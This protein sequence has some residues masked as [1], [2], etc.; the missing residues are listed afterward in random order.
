MGRMYTELNRDK[1]NK[2]L[3]RM[4]DFDHCIIPADG[5]IS[6]FQA[7]HK[8]I[9]KGFVF[10]CNIAYIYPYYA[11]LPQTDNFL[12]SMKKPS[13]LDQQLAKLKKLNLLPIEQDENY[14]NL[15]ELAA[16]ICETPIALITLLTEKEQLF[17]SHHGTNLKQTPIEQSFC[18]H[19]V[20][21]PNDIFIVTDAR[22]NKNFKDNPVVSAPHNFIFYAGVPLVCTSGEVLGA[23]CVID[24]AP[25]ELTPQQQNALK[26]LSKQVVQLL[27]LRRKDI[28]FTDATNKLRREAANYQT[29]QSKFNKTLWSLNER[30]KEQEC[31][32]KITYLS[33]SESSIQDLLEKSIDILPEGYQYP[34]FAGVAITYGHKTIAS[35]NYTKTRWTQTTER[36]CISGKQL[37]ISVSY[38][39]RITE[40][41]E[42][43]F[44]KE[45]RKLLESVTD[46][47]LLS[48][49]QINVI[50]SN[51]L[52]LQSTD[53]GIYGINEHGECT[54]INRAA[55]KMLGFEE[56]ECIGKNM[57]EIVHYKS[58]DGE[59][60]EEE[61][62]PIYKSRN[63]V[64]GCRVES[65]VFW[66]K[67]G[68]K[69]YVR[70]SSTPIRF[71]N[72]VKGAV[73]VFND[74]S[75]IKESQ[76]Q[77]R[78]S[79]Q[80]FKTLVQDGLDLIGIL[81]LEGNYMYVSPTSTT[82]L[83]ITPEE[84]IG[85][86]AFDFIH[87]DDKDD[88]LS[89][90]SKLAKQKS[91]TIS[92]FRFIDGKGE[93]RWIESKV[94]NM[95]DNPAIGGIVAN[96]RD[97]TERLLNDER[98]MDSEQR[99]RALIENGTDGMAIIR[100][101]GSTSYISP[102]I[103]SVLG[104]SEKEAYRLN[105]FEIIHTED[106]PKVIEKMELVLKSPGVPIQGH[107]S[108][109]KHKD[110]SWR[111]LEATITN[112]IHDPNINGIVDNFRDVT[113]RIVADEKI[114]QSEKRFKSLVQEG[115]DLI[116]I[117]DFQGGF[118]YV[119]PNY[120][121]YLGYNEK[122]LL[123]K[124]GFSLIHPEDVAP[125][126]EQ[127]NQL[128][129]EKRIKSNPYRF[130][131]KTNGWRWMQSIGT[132]LTEDN[133]ISGIVV[134]SVDIT[135]LIS[136]QE[137][138]KKSNERFE[139][140]SK[141]TNDAIYDWDVEKDEFYW[142]DGFYRNFGYN[143]EGKVFTIEDWAA[144]THPI[145]RE[146]H[147]QSWD[148]FL[149]DKKRHLWTN[150]FR[151]KTVD[152]T[153]LFVEE[154]GHMIRDNKGKPIRMIGALRDITEF[155]RIEEQKQLQLAITN[156]FKN[157][158]RLLVCVENAIEHIL[159]TDEYS[160]CAV[161]LVSRDEQRLRLFS[162]SATNGASEFF[163]HK[164]AIQEFGFGEGVPGNVW[165]N[166]KASVWKN[167]GENKEFI[168]HRIAKKL[169]LKSVIG[170]PLFQHDSVVGVMILTSRSESL[171]DQ[172][173]PLLTSIEH[174]FGAE[175]KRKQQEEEFQ[176]FFE[177]APEILAIASA[178][179]SFSK[180]NPAFCQ[181]LGYT[182]KELTSQPFSNFIYPDD[183]SD[184]LQEYELNI[185][186]Q[187]KASGFINRYRKKS[188]E[189]C[190]ISWSSSDVFDQEGNIF[191]YGRDITE[192]KELQILLGNASK[193]AQ[194][195]SWEIDVLK[196]TVFW[197]DI[198]R[199]IREV[200]DSFEPTLKKGIGGF[201]KGHD[202][203]TIS[204][205][206]K[207]CIEDGTPWDEEL[208]IITEKGNL[209]WIRTIGEATFAE[210]K[211]IK[212]YGSFQDIHTKKTNEL[213]LKKTLNEKNNILESIGD[214][215]LS[216][217]RKWT[218]TY[219]NKE[220]E[221]I[222]RKNRKQTLGK[223]LWKVFSKTQH[224]KFYAEYSKAMETQ[225]IVHFEEYNHTTKQWLEVSVYPSEN[226]LSV[227]MKDIS[228]RVESEEQVRLSN[229]RFEKVSEATNDAIWDWDI[230]NKKTHWG[231]GYKTIFGYDPVKHPPTLETWTSRIHPEDKERVLASMNVLLEDKEASNW[232]HEYRYRKE[233]GEY[234]FVI[235]RGVAIRNEKGQTVRMVGAL[236]DITHRKESEESLIRLNKE[237]EIQ[238][239]E[240]AI[241]NEELEQFA[242]VTS[243]DL[244]EPLRMITSFLN[245]LQRKYEDKLDDKAQRYIHFAVDGA[246]RM[247]QII[248]DLLEFSRAGRLD[249]FSSA[250]LID[251]NDLI[252]EV[253]I[254]H[255]KK[256]VETKANIKHDKL[257]SI[258]GERTPLLQVF[259]NIISN[260]I[261]YQRDG[262]TPKVTIRAEEQNDHWL[263]HVEDN[264][265]GISD[266]YFDQI[267]IV[268]QRL[269]AREEYSGTGIGLSIV[270]KIIERMDGKIWV[271]SE[272][273]KG[274]AF[275]FT[276][277][278]NDLA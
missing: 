118:Q 258:L 188:G 104:Y 9:I 187:H 61:D 153:Y 259:Q 218:V 96:S 266:E 13:N 39:K 52:I 163:S 32:Y 173:I 219:W 158:E 123:G 169:G 209:K 122:E 37:E 217:D 253:K 124:D 7:Y 175:I 172:N 112:M 30:L 226:G 151:F 119:S 71:A 33:N 103:K 211:C 36:T 239:K 40:N 84:F 262:I 234:A 240:L 148:A 132:N 14:N 56:S 200:P 260:G 243:H 170:V 155:Q 256:I 3:K 140:V 156:F 182:A 244:Q 247:R 120:K 82:V 110:G 60:H 106:L 81:D 58:E 17:L 180:V 29:I 75:E 149:S 252:D 5:L 227:Y 265:I 88:F 83:G 249:E 50:T 179:G 198:T 115:A 35:Q 183:L 114:L 181:L 12:S 146:K 91:V 101:D 10:R 125:L 44:L 48:I 174:L 272:I 126:Y 127:L 94:T 102:S 237:L 161:W 223:N 74:I 268:F 263:F 242:F 51:Q 108:R 224:S 27:K 47:I 269:H 139:Y 273:G 23:L 196:G 121:Q 95:L 201:V 189:Y 86:N 53:E 87:P 93:W 186:S 21:K 167:I 267:F 232:Q 1:T 215:F 141:A 79:E 42:D 134:N 195:G 202:R 150:S 38:Q 171:S 214:A 191:A 225:K 85:K 11:K 190:W 24:H 19:A 235:D 98:L 230:L 136:A 248:L 22:K 92:P 68:T 142:G 254:L 176:L 89:N 144:L 205:K 31:L 107:T 228:L 246:Q 26:L 55:L 6:I 43:A 15:T 77:L 261:K 241:S 275:H 255:R 264:G 165:M 8:L 145:D 129:T 154:I 274:T 185:T 213:E 133:S 25:K 206:V 168:R 69:F 45:E 65:D 197:S 34:E 46:S 116:A 278:K 229:E 135:E 54:F 270:K 137:E 113:D 109:T 204:E 147:Q 131:H 257:P 138:L 184:T 4:C 111:W 152:N 194:V 18:A 277:P 130:K 76:E 64:K 16:S 63:L 70:Y 20:A 49:N 251:L 117:L 78:I 143:P 159:H 250:E 90:Y 66:K 41:H 59:I 99:F 199:E 192:I 233:S 276:I 271:T 164:N 160:T 222:L 238:T 28:E 72:K 100:P 212:I 216:V 245:Q 62:C 57:H 236:S 73:V 177:N 128:Q 210:G 231:K 67:D 80:R 221:N 97:I 157:E 162:S 2:A 207:Q 166:G 208:Q 178:D 105:L 220:A 193:L 203:D